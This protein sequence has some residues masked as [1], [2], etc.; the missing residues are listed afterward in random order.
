MAHIY[1]FFTADR[2]RWEEDGNDD[3]ISESGWVDWSWSPYVL[4]DGHNDVRP[5]V[6]CDETSGEELREEIAEALSKLPGGWENNGDGT[7]YSADSEMPFHDNPEGWSYSYALHFER[8]FYG[9]NGWT[10]EAWPVP[11]GMLP[12]ASK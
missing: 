9:P 8:K 1:A 6:D 7:F 10:V 5:A 3:P 4:H 11:Q 2:V 12:T